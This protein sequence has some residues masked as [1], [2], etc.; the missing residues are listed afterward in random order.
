MHIQTQI[1]WSC[2][3]VTELGN[4]YFCQIAVTCEFEKLG[5]AMVP[6]QC[7]TQG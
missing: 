5:V 3:F 6:N 4:I 7:H 2:I 1:E